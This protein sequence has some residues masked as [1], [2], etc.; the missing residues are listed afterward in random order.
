MSHTYRRQRQAGAWGIALGAVLCAQASAQSSAPVSLERQVDDAF[1][2]VLQQPQDLPLWSTYARLLVESGNYE[3]GI[4]ALERLL[5]DPAADPSIRVEVATLYFRLASYAIADAQV[6]QALADTRLQ[7]ARRDFAV[8]LQQESRRR[9]E[10]SQVSGSVVFGVRRQTNPTYAGDSRTVLIAG[11]PLTLPAAPARDADTDFNLAARLQHLY[12]LDMQNSATIVSSLGAYVADYRSSSG[13]LLV[14][15]RTTPY[16]LRVLDATVGLRFKPA[17]SDVEGLTLRPFVQVTDVNAQRHRF[18]TQ[19]TAGLEAVYEPTERTRYVASL[20]RQRR[21]FVN[22][23]DVPNYDLIGGH[24]TSLRVAAS[25]EVGAGQ[26][27]SGEYVMRSNSTGRSFYDFKSHEVRV[28]YSATYINP[29][30]KSGYWTTSLFAGALQR[31]YG[32]PDAAVSAT[33][34]RR[35]REWRAGIV[36]TVPLAPAWSLQVIA[37]HTRNRPNIPNFSYKNTSLSGAVVYSF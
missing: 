30:T 25:H 33:Q 5:V 22:R 26:L 12:D 7:G 4:A 17:P 28:T 27:L 2:Q 37:E 9:A 3:G 8:Y 35:D 15:G 34:T 32:G 1:R 31:N 18:L 24:L 6:T 21:R 11:T 23:V 20:D 13:S 36:Q 16:D 29:V 19:S 14:V 10:K